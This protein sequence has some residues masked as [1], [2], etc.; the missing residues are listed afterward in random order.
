MTTNPVARWDFTSYLN[1]KDEVIRLCNEFCKKFCFQQEKCPTT[2]RLHFQ[3]R[4]SLKTK[5]RFPKEFAKA[6][7]HVSPTSRECTDD[8][9][10]VTK[11]ETRVAGPWSE[12]DVPKYIPRDVRKV[13]ALLPWQ[14]TLFDISK[15]ENDRIIHYVYDNVGN[16]GKSVFTR[17]M[18]CNGHAQM[19]PMINDSKDIMRMVMDMPRS[20]TYI[21]DMP[22]AINKDRLFQLYGGIEMVKGGYCYD[23]RYHFRQELF[24]PPNLIIFSNALPEVS[25]LSKDRWMILT[26]QNGTLYQ[27]SLAQVKEMKKQPTHAATEEDFF[28]ATL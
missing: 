20:K 21:M 8:D 3:G 15:V 6:I 11:E 18:M 23:D 28:G 24:D 12:K 7:G 10:Y 9:F 26:V 17:W 5:V 16:I 1:D 4:V 2:D 14:Q 22:R 27:L 25:M 19:L 13:V